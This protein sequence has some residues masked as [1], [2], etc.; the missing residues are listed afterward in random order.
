M[1]MRLI[2]LVS[3]LLAT[4]LMLSG[5]SRMLL[6]IAR[7][8]L[9]GYLD[10]ATEPSAEDR[11]AIPTEAGELTFSEMEYT[12]PDM[13]KIQQTF[14]EACILAEGTDLDAIM[15]AIWAFYDEYDWFYTYYSLADIHYCLDVTDA[16][17]EEE[18]YFCSDNSAAVDAALEE[19]YYALAKSPCRE[20]LEGDD[21]FGEGFFDSYD[22][23]NN[24]DE[25]F[26]ALLR[27]ES[28]LMARYYDLSA[29]ATG[30][31]EGSDAWY[32]C[33][34]D[35]LAQVLVDLVAVRREIAAHWDY[36]SYA[37][38]AWD[39]YYY[40]DYTPAEME[41]YLEGVRRELVPIYVELASS[42]V[43][44]YGYIR[45]GQRQIY[46]YVRT[47]TEAMGGPVWEAFQV[48]EDRELYDITYSPN[49]YGVSFEMYLDCYEVPFLFLC[50]SLENRDKLTFAHEFGH[51]CNDYY[52]YGSSAGVDVLEVF[53]QGM[54]YLS[55]C[56]GE[57]TKR[58]ART[59]LADSI[60][61]YVEQSAFATFEHRLYELKDPTV[62][63]LYALYEEVAQDFGFWSVGYDP[64]EFV[65]IP[66]FF[67]NPMYIDSYVVSNDAAMQIYQLEL[68]EPGAGLKRFEEHLETEELW[69]LSFLETADLESPF[70]PGRLET[71][72]DLFRTELLG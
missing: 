57:D 60:S 33:Y 17:W 31:P 64:R 66:H 26:T 63:D 49:K 37:G 23:E 13:D 8:E 36:D 39:F 69:F 59:K 47:A 4:V 28:E 48:M 56:Y 22:G 18:Y 52:S 43:W 42:D 46:D 72:R 24:W 41:A 65:T 20:E 7:E 14:E 34:A 30:A 67:T 58:L 11:P 54:E 62:E 19:L 27:K 70:A 5:C 50:P 16:Y 25:S 12:R 2:R 32:D 1:K 9:D 15:D 38:F 61:T 3:L 45:M 51:F 68:D 44:D 55:L 53:S 71:V 21:Y 35:P 29:E 10:A 6:E 40:R